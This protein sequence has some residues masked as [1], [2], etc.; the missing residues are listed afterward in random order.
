MAITATSCPPIFVTATASG[1]SPIARSPILVNVDKSMRMSFP[2]WTQ[3]T[4]RFPTG[5]TATLVGSPSASSVATCCGRRGLRMST[6]PKRWPI[7]SEYTRYL[8]SRVTDTISALVAISSSGA[9][10]TLNVATGRN[11]PIPSRSSSPWPPCASGTA[12]TTLTAAASAH[13]FLISIDVLRP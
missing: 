1:P 9:R 11:E 4:A 13:S 7:A 12:V 2:G 10:G 6:K 3:A 8:P 5:R